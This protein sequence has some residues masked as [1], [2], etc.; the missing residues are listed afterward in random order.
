MPNGEDR[1]RIIVEGRAVAVGDYVVMKALEDCGCVIVNE[2]VDEAYRFYKQD[3][4]L[5]EDP[6]TALCRVRYLMKPP[7]TNFQ[8][9][10]QFRADYLL[11][12]IKDY[13]VDGVVWYELL[14]DELHDMEFATLAKRLDKEDVP[15]TRIQTSYE[16]TREAMGP[17]ITKIETMTSALR[18]RKHHAN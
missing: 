3:T 12:L 13:R 7:T 2:F 8:P 14:Y 9:A 18:E 15:I 16:Y 1:P 11:E 10:W 4:P 17:L 5:D 6:L